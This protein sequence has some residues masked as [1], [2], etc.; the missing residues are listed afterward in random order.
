MALL[1]TLEVH[2]FNHHNG[3]RPSSKVKFDCGRR[4][5]MNSML[6]SHRAARLT[7]WLTPNRGARPIM[8]GPDIV[9]DIEC[10]SEHNM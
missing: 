9:I 6:T 5:I 10:P 2:V 1:E 7:G 4:A 8:T 3:R